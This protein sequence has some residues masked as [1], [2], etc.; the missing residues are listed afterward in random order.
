MADLRVQGQ[1][2]DV[3]RVHQGGVGVQDEVGSVAVGGSVG[4]G[5]QQ[6]HHLHTGDTTKCYVHITHVL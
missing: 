3:V 2:V 1:C 5:N 4:H 6:I